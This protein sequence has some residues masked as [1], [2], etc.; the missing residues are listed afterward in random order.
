LRLEDRIVP[1]EVLSTMMFWALGSFAYPA[2]LAQ[3]SLGE[4]GQIRAVSPTA[5][6]DTDASASLIF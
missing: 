1:G 2:L 3:D 5:G 6:A 4:A